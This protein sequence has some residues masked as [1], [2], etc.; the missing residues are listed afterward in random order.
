MLILLCSGAAPAQDNGALETQERPGT[1][2]QT[3]L[4]W[5]PEHDIRSDAAIIYTPARDAIESWRVRGYIPQV[6]GGFRTGDSYIK[7]HPEEGQTAADGSI[8][9]CGPGSYYMVPTRS[10]IQAMVDFFVEA[11]HNGAR[12]VIPEEPEFFASA[13][14]SQ[15]FKDEWQRHYN[16]PW[17]DPASSHAAR[18]K[19][20]QLKAQMEYRMI[21]SIFTA[22]KE[23]DATVTRMLAHH[24][25][26]NYHGWGISFPFHQFM[27]MGDLQEVI[28][29]VWTGT[30]R[31]P[32]MYRGQTAERTFE[33]AL[34]EYSSLVELYRGTDK[35]LWFLADP[36]EDNPDRTMEDYRSNYAHT[37]VASLMFAEVNAYELLP[38]PNRIYGRIPAEYG[39]V[40]GCVF[41]AL[42]QISGMPARTEPS[43]DI[44]ILISDSL[45]YQRGAPDATGLNGFYGLALPFVYRGVPVRVA[46]L[47]RATEAAFLKTFRTLLVSYDFMKPMKPEYNQALAQWVKDG[48]KLVLVNGGDPYDN[49]PLWWHD[50]GLA[51]PGDHLIAQLG[52]N[53]SRVGSP[54][55]PS[56]KFQEIARESEPVQDLSNRREIRIPAPAELAEGG[57]TLIRLSDSQP[58]DGWGA[59]VQEIRIQRGG[60]SVRITPGTPQELAL[61]YRDSGSHLNAAG[62]RFMDTSSS[63]IY[64]IEDVTPGTQLF[65]TIANQYLIETAA[66]PAGARSALVEGTVRYARTDER[67][68]PLQ[69]FESSDSSFQASVGEGTFV[70]IGRPP[71]NFAMDPNGAEDLVSAVLGADR[72]GRLS[73][74]AFSF[75]VE[76]GPYMARHSIVE[77]TVVGEG[78]WIDLMDHRLPVLKSPTIGKGESR[79]FRRVTDEQTPAVLA[80]TYETRVEQQSRSQMV[81][82][83]RGPV[84]VPAAVRLHLA[85]SP[86]PRVQCENDKG[87]P[88]EHEAEAAEGTLYIT[89]PGSPEGVRVTLEW[90]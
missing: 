88:V 62:Q 87:E 15:S 11:V 57:G 4:P 17:Q 86:E 12:A 38:W 50:L 74:G 53:T 40:L 31:T 69:G 59:L 3:A 61:V 63:V 80:A 26:V 82:F 10:R 60:E 25:P 79:L 36:L 45:A 7:E 22:V 27:Q 51:A 73:K 1:S 64:L 30:A 28:G 8:L 39:T 47:E 90:P 75:S 6:M 54:A 76:R 19:A 77:D 67:M 72:Q 85:G 70:F 14:Y 16:E 20:E 33:N 68:K 66:A 48:G 41:N 56:P 43:D 58:A 2:F 5:H 35:R 84:R 34:L 18:I 55:G 52:L 71:Q 44:G 32:C 37:L 13:G 23:Q 81:L 49:A 42:G 78:Q 9:T 65:L 83:N 21:D 24:S 46:P 89:F 29:Q